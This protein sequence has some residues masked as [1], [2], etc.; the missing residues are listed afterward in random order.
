M[1]PESCA[2]K[3]DRENTSRADK[4]QLLLM[5]DRQDAISAETVLFFADDNQRLLDLAKVLLTVIFT[6]LV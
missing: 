1:Q 5:K 6:A 2:R 3:G 4:H